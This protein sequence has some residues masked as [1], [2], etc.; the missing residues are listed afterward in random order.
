[1]VGALAILLG[2]CS[3]LPI[4]GPAPVGGSAG[5]QPCADVYSHARCELIALAAAVDLGLPRDAIA[6]A[7][8]PWVGLDANG[9]PVTLGG[10]PRTEVQVTLPDGSTRTVWMC[11]GVSMAPMCQDEPV[12][13]AEDIIGSGYR[14]VPCAGEPP[15]GCATL[16]PART[17]AA[18]AGAV[19][20]R[21]DRLDIPIDHTGDYRVKVGEARLPNGWLTDASFALVDDW[22]DGVTILSGRA[23]MALQS[24]ESDGKPFMNVYEH[25]W[26][27]GT[28]R[29]AAFIVFHV[30]DFDPGAVLSIKDVVVE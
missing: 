28:E 13:R 3:S 18:T 27:E 21:V 14:D 16:V 6:I 19:P 2:A 1:M 4:I 11:G 17:R 29:V 7:I 9:R 10:A 30:D 8:V 23:T 20:L 26:R 24:L 22:P 5:P 25:G 15:D 12:V